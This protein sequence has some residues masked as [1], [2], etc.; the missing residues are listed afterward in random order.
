MA[1][2]FPGGNF[3]VRMRWVRHFLGFMNDDLQMVDTSAISDRLAELR[4]FL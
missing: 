3:L 1:G 4:R 2:M